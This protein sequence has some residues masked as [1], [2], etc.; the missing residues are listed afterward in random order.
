LKVCVVDPDIVDV[1]LLRFIRIWLILSITTLGLRRILARYQ[2]VFVLKLFAMVAEIIILVL[3][4]ICLFN[5]SFGLSKQARRTV[6]DLAAWLNC[7]LAVLG[8][9]Y[10]LENVGRLVLCQ[11]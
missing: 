9:L 5:K 3:N 2:Q 7:F 6:G 10:G 11:V 4:C 1:V 8:V